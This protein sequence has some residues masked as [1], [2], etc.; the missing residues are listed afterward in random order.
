MKLLCNVKRLPLGVALAILMIGA[1]WARADG[2]V[3][4]CYVLSAGVDNYPNEPKLSG[5]VNDARNATNAFAA[6]QGKLFG[7]VYA[8][9]LVDAEATHANILKQMQDFTRLGKAGDFF[10]FFLSGHGSFYSDHQTWYF[11]PYDESP[12]NTNGDLPQSQI[13][14]SADALVQQGKKVV[15]IIDACFSGQLA[16]AA[17]PYLNRYQDSRGG[18]L[19]LFLSSSS[20]QTS[21]AL[22]QYSA[23]A[24][25]FA[26]GMAG[27]ADLNHDGTITLSELASYSHNHTYELLRK[28]NNNKQQDSSTFFSKSISPNMP[29]ALLRPRVITT[30]VNL[31]QPPASRPVAQASAVFMGGETLP[32]FGP[33]T[34]EMFGGGRAVMVDAKERSEGVWQ[35]NGTQVTL[36]FSGGR[37]VYTG[38]LTNKLITGTATNG[39]ASW[40]WSVARSSVAQ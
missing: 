10:V 8:R 23:F 33:L 18:G 27:N 3:P 32:G 15:V 28:N 17:Q 16:A 4:D 37:V 21:N 24:R 38:N 6:Q 19:I 20:S 7:K 35:Q 36:Q 29:L 26:D 22:G 9:T 13:L 39:Q 25:A 2:P 31:P 40:S 34:F 30:T 1:G 14:D 12:N 11:C 5:D